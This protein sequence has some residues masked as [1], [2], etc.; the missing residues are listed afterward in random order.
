MII[1][2][3]RP[4]VSV[5]VYECV[6]LYDP[7]VHVCFFFVLFFLHCYLHRKFQVAFST[8][9]LEYHA[10][11][12]FLLFYRFSIVVGCGFRDYSLLQAQTRVCFDVLK[13]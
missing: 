6:S 3:V 8:P 9:D 4:R 5:S 2:T 13:V 10:I 11:V 12:F 7:R 1:L